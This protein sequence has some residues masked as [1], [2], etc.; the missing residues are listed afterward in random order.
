MSMLRVSS[1]KMAYDVIVPMDLTR[2][3]NSLMFTCAAQPGLSRI[4]MNMLDF[5]GKAIRRRKA[6]ELCGGPD[7]SPRYCIDKTFGQIRIQY[8]NSV[9]IGLLRRG[10]K[11]EDI[12][13]KG[14]AFVQIRIQR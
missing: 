13:R 10:M 11:R 2:F 14:L 12:P 9:F 8:S 4:L 7:N 5:E 6:S 3:L 1:T